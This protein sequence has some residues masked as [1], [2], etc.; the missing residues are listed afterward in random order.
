MIKAEFEAKIAATN[1]A[2]TAVLKYAPGMFETASEMVGTK[3]LK[4]DGSLRKEAEESFDLPKSR[5]DLQVYRETSKYNLTFVFKACVSYKN[6]TGCDITEYS[7]QFLHIGSLFDGVLQDVSK[8]NPSEYKNDYDIEMVEE[9]LRQRDAAKVE[10]ERAKSA[11][12]PF[13][14]IRLWYPF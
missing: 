9:Y 6:A 2:N 4:V 3:I 8:F 11:C 7:E 14:E 1:A 5:H 12:G 13:S 10:Y